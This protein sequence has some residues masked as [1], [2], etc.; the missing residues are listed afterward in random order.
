MKGT[1][2]IKAFKLLVYGLFVLL[3]GFLGLKNLGYKPIIVISGSMEPNILTNSVVII[4]TNVKYGDLKVGDVINYNHQEHKGVVH[5]IFQKSKTVNGPM[6]LTSGVNTKTNQVIDNWVVKNDM[7]EGKVIKVFNWVAPIITFLFGNLVH[8][9]PIHIGFGFLVITI[10]L[11]SLIIFSMKGVLKMGENR[12]LITDVYVVTEH[13]RNK[14]KAKIQFKGVLGK[15]LVGTVILSTVLGTVQPVN[16]QE[17]RESYNLASNITQNYESSIEHKVYEVR[18]T[19]SKINDLKRQGLVTNEILK[20][21]TNQLLDL[22]KAVQMSGNE[23]I[24]EVEKVVQEVEETIKGVKGADT[25]NTVVSIMRKSLKLSEKIEIP[26]A[27]SVQLTDITNHWGKANI[28]RLVGMKAISGYPDGTFQ[29]NR[30]IS[31][32]EF[33]KIAVS[34]VEKNIKAAPQGSHWASGVYTTAIEKGIIKSSEFA[35][36]KERFDSTITREDMALILV[37][38]N[39]IS[40]GNSKVDTPNT[41]GMIQDYNKISS[42]RT[43]FV[44]QAFQKNLLKGKGNGFDPKGNLTRAEA[45]TAVINLLDYKPGTVV[46]APKSGTEKAKEVFNQIPVYNKKTNHGLKFEGVGYT[47]DDVAVFAKSYLSVYLNYDGT[48]KVN[49]D[50]WEQEVLGYMT[51]GSIESV[52]K[53]KQIYIESKDKCKADIVVD[54]SKIEIKNGNFI[55]HSAFYDSVSGKTFKAEVTIGGHNVNKSEIAVGYISIKEVK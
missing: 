46:Q 51:T 11:V 21:L 43:Y 8:I 26:Q 6:Y 2:V 50:K 15:I 12:E 25:V 22:E 33:L 5:R 44:E 27:K 45:A 48:D 47:L 3:I 18:D 35:G 24:E 34:S 9:N 14:K 53:A 49:M 36:T 32:A 28:E 23:S 39:E 30:T 55:V 38:L 16:A 7:Y 40:Q 13:K 20:T 52:A 42:S 17:I 37:R 19:I 31:F 4:D 41:K 1:E 29:P 10:T 54:A